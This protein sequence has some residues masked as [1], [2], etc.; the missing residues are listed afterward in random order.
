MAGKG[1][2]ALDQYLSGHFIHII[3]TNK[4]N[5]VVLVNS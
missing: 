5:V 1:A 2:E 4:L 3:V